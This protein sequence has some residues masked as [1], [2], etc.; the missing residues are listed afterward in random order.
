MDRPIRGCVLDVRKIG[1]STFHN[2][3]FKN[4]NVDFKKS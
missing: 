1:L 2:K 4:V 3:Y